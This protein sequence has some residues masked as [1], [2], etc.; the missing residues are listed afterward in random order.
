MIL[1]VNKVAKKEDLFFSGSR[2]VVNFLISTTLFK[3][4]ADLYH[5]RAL[6]D[7]A[8]LVRRSALFVIIAKYPALVGECSVFGIV[9]TLNRISDS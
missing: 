3:K 5:F 1:I 2:L 9:I 7:S 6:T 4:L 8:A